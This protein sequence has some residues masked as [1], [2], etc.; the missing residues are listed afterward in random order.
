ML[1]FLLYGGAFKWRSS[2]A[3][4]PCERGFFVI[5]AET[6]LRQSFIHFIYARAFKCR[7]KLIVF[8]KPLY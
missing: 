2:A 3:R 8:M 7:C 6:E 1:A 5:I 4:M